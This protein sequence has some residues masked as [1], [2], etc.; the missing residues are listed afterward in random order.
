MSIE[1]FDGNS[2]YN[3]QNG[4]PLSA[5]ALNELASKADTANFTQNNIAYTQGAFGTAMSIDIPYQDTVLRLEQFQI[6]AE[7][8]EILGNESFSIIRVVKGEVVWNPKLLEVPGV[9]MPTACTTQITIEN[10]FNLPT[11]P[12]ID[13][14]SSTYIGDGG[15]R[16]PN[17]SGVDIG[18]FIFKATNL[19]TDI[20]PII[21]AA[22]DYAPSCPVVFP[23]TPPVDGAVWECVKIGSVTYIEPDPEAEPPV[24][25]GWQITQNFIGSMTLPGDGKGKGTEQNVLPAQLK[26]GGGGGGA[27]SPFQVQITE[28]NGQRYIQMATGSVSYS[29]SDMPII[30]SG[31]FTHTKQAWFNKVQI[32]PSGTR[33]DY[34]DIWPSPSVDPDPSW[35]NNAMDGGGGFRLDDTDEQYVIYAFK[36]DAGSA[37]GDVG[38]FVENGLPTLGIFKQSNGTDINKITKDP[39]PSIYEQTMNIQYMTGYKN[40]DTELV[41]DWGH[42]HTTWLNPRKLGYNYKA[43]ASITSS[44][45]G[46]FA[47]YIGFEQV[48]VPLICNTI[49]YVL[50]G[51]E[52]SGGAIVFSYDGIPSAVPFPVTD[53]Y[54]PFSVQESDEVALFRS[55]NAIPSLTG[56]VQ[57][58]K[59][60]YRTYY[61]TFINK[62]QGLPVPQITAN[63]SGV[64]SFQKRFNVI[65]FHTGN[66]DLTTPMQMGMTQLM[67]ESGL[68]E[69]DDP[70]N[71]NKES[72][73]AWKDI[74]N[75]DDCIGCK[76]FEGDVITDGVY[77]MGGDEPKNPDFTI[78]G[79]CNGG[80]CEHPFQVHIENDGD[81]SYF[82]VCEGMVNNIIATGGGQFEYFDGFIWV[83]NSASDDEFPVS[84]D[85]E[86]GSSV[87]AD[88]ESTSY[89]SIARVT[90]QGEIFQLLTGSL[91]GER[92]KCGDKPA[93]YWY[94]RV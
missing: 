4:E 1:G 39:G 29:Q 51:G 86:S 81:T 20:P 6:V 40:S 55:L 19:P 34:N 46:P 93:R 67:N 28:V 49:Q 26:T 9:P 58:S 7:P 11:F 16:V 47:C 80:V 56:N 42:C 74:I 87:P 36:W 54:T 61:I 60:G 18:I 43:I 23:G 76:D 71:K 48:G 53:V 13:D 27:W 77:P 5:R 63:I 91:W 59:G 24:A 52:P 94:A 33:T 14:D 30:N 70:Y 69:A 64:T 90:S 73:P 22:P 68:T 83:A 82:T 17:V 50:L 75:R 57:V 85:I 66:L 2:T 92:F 78:D 41:G 37:I 8:Y 89:I 10:W 84:S 31:A 35:S 45:A 3:F 12:I 88:D 79:G 62:L 15:I 38:P 44:N 25:G 72:D 32:C 65:Q 21:I